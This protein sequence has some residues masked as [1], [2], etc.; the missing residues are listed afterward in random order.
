VKEG[1]SV[2]NAAAACNV[3]KST[4]DDMGLWE[5]WWCPGEASRADQGGGGPDHRDGGHD[6]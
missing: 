4:I 6:V 3:P 2:R 1:M 5:A